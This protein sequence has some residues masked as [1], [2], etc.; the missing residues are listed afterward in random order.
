[1][2]RP[3]VFLDD[4][5]V[6][7]DNRPRGAQWQRLVAQ[8][9]APRLG[10]PPAAWAEANREVITGFF[11]PSA[12]QARLLAAAD[13]ES[14]ER[15]YYL[16]WLGGMCA[17][18]GVPRPPEEESI[19]LSREATAWVLPQVRSAYPGAVET[20]R[21]LHARG[22]AL[23]TASGSSSTDLEG[24]LQGMGVRAC[25]GRLYGPDLIGTFKVGPEFYERLLADAGVSPGDALV[26]DDNPDAVKWAAPGGLVIWIAGP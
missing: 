10:G 1:M 13:Y 24:Y 15:A 11:E 19:A 2:A 5:G 18:V 26:L 16:D 22:Y 21:L 4:G 25:F 6:L 7:N 3:V 8:Y 23:H 12:W 20:V 17:I 14:F 9:F